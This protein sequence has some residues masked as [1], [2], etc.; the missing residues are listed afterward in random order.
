MMEPGQPKFVTPSR[1]PTLPPGSTSLTGPLPSVPEESSGELGSAVTQLQGLVN[2]LMGGLPPDQRSQVQQQG[3]FQKAVESYEKSLKPWSKVWKALGVLAAIVAVIFG[4][5]VAY[6]QFLGG[7]ATKAD[8][9]D[10]MEKDL[11]P[12]KVQVEQNTKAITGVQE[13][14]T[15]LLNRGEAEAKVE[16]AQQVL[17]IYRQ[18]HEDRI[19]EWA[20]AKAAGRTRR[21][22]PQKRPELINAEVEVQKA[23]KKLLQV[24]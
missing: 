20:A 3:E 1:T 5:G 10:H 13:G 7:N 23:Q 11:V 12:V 9:V 16:E 8:I 2:Q 18:E 22:R 15:T 19:A 21:P 24:K 17:D 14:V 6:Q 4:A